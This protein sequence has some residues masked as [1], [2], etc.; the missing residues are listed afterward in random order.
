MPLAHDQPDNADR[1]RRLGAGDWLAPSRF[2]GPAVADKLRR[3]L[4][5]PAVAQ[6]C[7][8]VAARF[9]G[10]DP[11]APACEAIEGLMARRSTRE[12]SLPVGS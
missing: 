3:L 7:R 6:A 1:V 9:D 10:G 2:R 4:G 11:L 12:G 8:H 5:V